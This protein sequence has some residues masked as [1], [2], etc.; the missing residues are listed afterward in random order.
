MRAS[1]LTTAAAAAAIGLIGFTAGA[2]AQ[3]FGIYVGP[4]GYD[5]DDANYPY[6][7]P[8]YYPSGPQVYGYTRRY[9]DDGTRAPRQVYRGDCGTYRFWNGDRC[10]DA[11]DK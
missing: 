7:S 5:D 4:G 8:Y 1:L 11:R 10:V 3:S 9:D 2:S 6:A